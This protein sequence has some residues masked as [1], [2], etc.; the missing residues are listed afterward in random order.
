MSDYAWSVGI[1]VGSKKAQKYNYNENV[2]SAR[3]IGIQYRLTKKT[4]IVWFSENC[5]NIC[6]LNK[7]PKQVQ[8]NC[9]FGKKLLKQ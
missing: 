1:I 9:W 5:W 6:W 4:M 7:S 8:W 2:V 3:I